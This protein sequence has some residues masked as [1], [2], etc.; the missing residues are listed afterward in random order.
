MGE[1]QTRLS[2]K[3]KLSKNQKAVLAACQ[4]KTRKLQKDAN[5]SDAELEQMRRTIQNENIV[6][7]ETASPILKPHK[8][9]EPTKYY[10]APDES[11][12]SGNIRVAREN[13]QRNKKVAAPT[14]KE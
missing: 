7:G 13:A 5:I 14:S 6:K 11:V 9:V 4:A 12:L 3:K 10:H 1:S 2:E 8:P